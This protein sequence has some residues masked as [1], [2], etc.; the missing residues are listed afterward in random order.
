MSCIICLENKSAP[1]DGLTKPVYDSSLS[2]LN[3]TLLEMANQGAGKENLGGPE[4]TG[5]D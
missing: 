4:S 3:Q 1:V 2:K 5:R